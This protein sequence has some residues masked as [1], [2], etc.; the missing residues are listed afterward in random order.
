ML[1]G[2]ELGVALHKTYV[3]ARKQHGVNRRTLLE[4]WQKKYISSAPNPN[5]KQEIHD[6]LRRAREVVQY[7][8]Q[9][10]S[11]PPSLA[12]A[13]ERFA[14][15]M[16]LSMHPQVKLLMQDVAKRMETDWFPLFGSS[17]FVVLNSGGFMGMNIRL[18][19]G[20]EHTADQQDIDVLF[21][22]QPTLQIPDSLY[23][24]VDAWFDNALAHPTNPA[25][26][27]DRYHGCRMLLMPSRWHKGNMEKKTVI[28]DLQSLTTWQ[29]TYGFVFGLLPSFPHSK[30]HDTIIWG[31]QQLAKQDMKAWEKVVSLMELQWENNRRLNWGNSSHVF[32]TDYF[33][34][35]DS[36]AS[37]RKEFDDMSDAFGEARYRVFS[38]MLR[39]TAL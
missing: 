29:D 15:F 7:F 13:E 35:D 21:F 8:S 38:D 19:A 10:E 1:T 4:D 17:S 31:L 32:K 14:K 23:E 9:T 24:K 34:A 30:N 6:L 3:L 33:T 12:I 25:L 20:R 27:Q 16:D 22:H 26:P 5:R 2:R 11:Q 28:A 18:V 36:D 39:A 37:F